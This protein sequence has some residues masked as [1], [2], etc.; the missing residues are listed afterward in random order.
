MVLDKTGTLTLG[1]P[2]VQRI[3]SAAGVTAETVLAAAAAAELRSEHPLGKA[4][5]AYARKTGCNVVE[6]AAVHLH[7]RPRH[8]RQ[9]RSVTSLWSE[10]KL[11]MADN[12]IAAPATCGQEAEAGAEVFVARDRDTARLNYRGGHHSS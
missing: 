1:K 7:P 8:Y 12:G 10:A 4:I 5:V 3:V 2:D 6:P 9:S 11:W